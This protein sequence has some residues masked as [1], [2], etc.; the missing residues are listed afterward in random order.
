SHRRRATRWRPSAA[1]RRT[2]RNAAV[3]PRAAVRRA[4]GM[5]DDHPNPPPTAVGPGALIGP[6]R[7]AGVVVDGPS[8]TLYEAVETTSGR[9]VALRRLSD[10]L[11]HDAAAI[12]HFLDAAGV[13]LPHPNVVAAFG[14]D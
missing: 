5:P 7:I 12:D 2:E 4:C 8:G 14:L 13:R 1:G 6:Y 3:A 10:R 9:R 11:A